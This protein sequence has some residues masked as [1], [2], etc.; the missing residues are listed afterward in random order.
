MLGSNLS[1]DFQEDNEGLKTPLPPPLPPP[2]VDAKCLMY[3]LLLQSL[4]NKDS[5]EVAIESSFVQ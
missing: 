3:I 5:D 4:V 1:R 2:L